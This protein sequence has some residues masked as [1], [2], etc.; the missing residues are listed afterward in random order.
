MGLQLLL[1]QIMLPVFATR[2]GY[3]SCRPDYLEACLARILGLYCSLIVKPANYYIVRGRFPLYQTGVAKLTLNPAHIF[4]LLLPPVVL[5]L[6]LLRIVLLHFWVH[7]GG[8]LRKQKGLGL[9]RALHS[10]DA[11]YS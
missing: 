7:S 10:F 8:P 4:S 6:V 1:P 5:L 9:L 11:V 2:K 3:L